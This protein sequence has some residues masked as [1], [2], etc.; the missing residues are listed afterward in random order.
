MKA[1]MFG[2][3]LACGLLF[4]AP[5]WAAVPP[6][7]DL[8]LSYHFAPTNET[9]GYRLY[10]PP[11]YDG[12]KSMPL[13]VVLHG[14]GTTEDRV[15]DGPGG[16]EIMR[17]AREHGDI[18]L[19]PRGYSA[20]GGFGDIYPVVVTRE[21]AKEGEE[22][23]AKRMAATKA[24]GP[25]APM[26]PRGPRPKLADVAVPADDFVEQAKGALSDWRTNQLS[27]QETYAALDQVRA[28][29]KIDPSRIYL[30]GN[31]MG[32]VGA[33]YL[34][35]KTPELWA[36][37]APG[38]GPVAA[39]TYP[40]GRLRAAKLPML[41]VHGEYDEHANP[42][43]SDVLASAARAE[44]VDAR[45]LVVKGGHHGDAWIM[46]LPEIFDFF[47]AHPRHP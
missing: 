22:M 25:A 28:A 12:S 18:V 40:F 19:V 8:H 11:S 43:W 45:L 9:M 16:A 32:G 4:G 37:V 31:S 39:W 24:G 46:A 38:G 23:A 20:F 1:T 2:A 29:Y 17:L 5:C 3:A 47:D 14:S 44:G 7:G 26:G 42:H 36:A 35:V 41:F 33:A 15:L 34:A 6:T 10:V 30:V 21:T 13:V 27:E